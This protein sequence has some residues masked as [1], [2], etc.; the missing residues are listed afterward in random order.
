[1]KEDLDHK[2]IQAASDGNVLY[3]KHYLH[4]GADLM[5]TEVA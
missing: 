2:L 5:A 4:K 3:V 1:M